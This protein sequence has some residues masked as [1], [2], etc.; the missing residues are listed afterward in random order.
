MDLVTADETNIVGGDLTIDGCNS[1]WY[2]FTLQFSLEL[3]EL[4]FGKNYIDSIESQFA[5]TPSDSCPLSPLMNKDSIKILTMPTPPPILS[6][7]ATE[8]M[9]S[10]MSNAE[11][12]YLNSNMLLAI[13]Y[14][15]QWD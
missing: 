2:S 4:L 1:N 14:V 6:L 15:L 13:L 8:I 10:P 5:T 9:Q 3:L 7:A 11:K 12:M